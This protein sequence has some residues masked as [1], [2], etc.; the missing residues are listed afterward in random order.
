MSKLPSKCLVDT[1]VPA[2]ANLSARSDQCSDVPDCCILESISQIENITRKG[3]CLVVDHAGEIFEEYKNNLSLGG[4]PGVGDAFAK[5]VS[6]NQWNP[7]KV[8]RVQITKSGNS[9]EEFPHHDELNDFDPSDRKFVAVANVHPDKPLILQGTDSKWW[10][11][12]DALS[13]VEITVCFICREYIEAK[14]MEKIGG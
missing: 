14:Y 1:N 7:G 9:Y 4:Q 10:G 11:W 5:W 8:D 3:A 6:D 12:N 2:T 13:E